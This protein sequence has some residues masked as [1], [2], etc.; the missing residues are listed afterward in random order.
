MLKREEAIEDIKELIEYLENTGG[1]GRKRS[2][3]LVYKLTE[4]LKFLES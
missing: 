3:A 4:V 1:M 2:E